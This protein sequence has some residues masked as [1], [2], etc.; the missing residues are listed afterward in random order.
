MTDSAVVRGFWMAALLFLA[1]SGGCTPTA[2]LSWSPD[3]ARAAYFVPTGGKLLPGV[4]YLLDGG[5]KTTARLGP[6]F[7]SFA[8]SADSKTVY[9][10]AYDNSPAADDVADRE[11]LVDPQQPPPP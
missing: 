5:G 4:G 8:W 3:G 10:G 1:M 11:W 2:H 7:G 9:F 6:T